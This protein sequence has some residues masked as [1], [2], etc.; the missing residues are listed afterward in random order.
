M[1]LRAF[2]LPGAANPNSKREEKHAGAT[3]DV[4][5][6]SQSTAVCGPVML[7]V[8]VTPSEFKYRRLP[9]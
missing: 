2:F 1:A 3:A 8:S 5:F 6:Q 9:V 4:I 7:F